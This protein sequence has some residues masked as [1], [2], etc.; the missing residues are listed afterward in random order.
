MSFRPPGATVGPTEGDAVTTTLQRYAPLSTSELE[1]A[2]A[3]LDGWTG[4]T[5]RICR[6]VRPTDLWALLERVA[7]VESAIDHHT[8][9]DL[10]AGSVTFT[11]WSHV[12]GVVTAADVE[13][14]RRLDAVLG[15][16]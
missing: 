10:D 12:A 13:L 8:V 16:A 4:D 15:D 11:L 6:R 9:V 7:E 2:L 5:T 1:T 3:G 14:A